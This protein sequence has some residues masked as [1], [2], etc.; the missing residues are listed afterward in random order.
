MLSIF[1]DLVS[2]QFQAALNTLKRC[3][4]QC[5]DELWQKPVVNNPFSQSVF[6]CLFFTDLYLCLNIE[7]QPKQDFHKNHADIF[8]DYEQ[9]EDGNPVGTYEK[10][11]IND[12]LEFCLERV[13]RTV[14]AEDEDE[15]FTTFAGF[16]WLSHLRR[17]EVHLYNIR[18]I[19]HH[20]AQLVAVLRKEAGIEIGWVKSG[21]E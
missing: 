19:Q 11:F 15:L 4:D 7:K 16:P 6:H 12:Y 17:A 10:S 1:Q 2:N 20:A 9:L 18:H 5:P 13:D 3:V 21:N 8:A 14:K